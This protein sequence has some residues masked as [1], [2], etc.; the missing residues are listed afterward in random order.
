[1]QATNANAASRDAARQNPGSRGNR[2]A[3]SSRDRGYNESMNNQKV[4]NVGKE[5]EFGSFP[6]APQNI[7]QKAVN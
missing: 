4:T 2:G 1:M 6:T 3:V 5:P 7:A